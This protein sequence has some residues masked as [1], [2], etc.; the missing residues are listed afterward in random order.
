MNIGA[1]SKASGLS[2]KMIRYYESV[3]L[4]P[5]AARRESNYR[6]YDDSDMHR[7]TFVRRARELGFDVPLIRDLLS[8]WSDR[9]RSNAE[10]R[11]VTMKHVGAME[12]QARKLQEMIAA[13]R[14]LVSACQHSGRPDC[15]IITELAGGMPASPVPVPHDAVVP[16][17]AR[18]SALGTQMPNT[19]GAR[20]T[21]VTPKAGRDVPRSG[22]APAR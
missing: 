3:G 17:F 6:D 18:N 8:L 4:L 22:R 19:S 15:P 7:L 5:E 10:V 9:S 2:A 16:G 11:A 13:L 12:E 20:E 1:A 14:G 21:I